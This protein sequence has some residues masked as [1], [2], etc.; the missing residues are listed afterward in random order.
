MRELSGLV[1]SPNCFYPSHW[2]IYKLP[3]TPKT[4]SKLHGLHLQQLLRMYL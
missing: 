2:S 3:A 1:A 4:H